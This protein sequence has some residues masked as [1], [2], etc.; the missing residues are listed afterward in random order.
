MTIAP[1][2]LTE[3]TVS[4]MRLL[5]REMGVVNTARFLNQFTTGYGNYTEEREQLFGAMTVDEIATEIKRT[6]D[7]QASKE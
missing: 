7:Q 2:P 6:R 5:C 3:I 1:T 4:A